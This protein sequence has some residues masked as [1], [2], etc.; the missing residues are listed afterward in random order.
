MKVSICGTNM[1]S[2]IYENSDQINLHLLGIILAK[3]IYRPV[4]VALRYKLVE[5]H[6]DFRA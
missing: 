2:T 4:N 1:K 5:N 3:S 6:Y